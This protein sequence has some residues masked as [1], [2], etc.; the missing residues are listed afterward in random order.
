MSSFKV[1]TSPLTNRIYA[2]RV[3]KDGSFVGV[4]YDITRDAI[5]SVAQHLWKADTRL[6]FVAEGKKYEL[7]VC[8]TTTINP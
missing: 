5:E 4:K 1:G 7:K 3:S 8:E 6:E 2:G